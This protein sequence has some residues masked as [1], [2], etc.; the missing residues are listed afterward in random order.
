[1]TA[2]LQNRNPVG[3]EM[4]KARVSTNDGSE[5]DIGDILLVLFFFFLNVCVYGLNE[6]A[7]GVGNPPGA[8]VVGC[9]EVAS[10]G[11]G[12]ELRSSAQLLSHLSRLFVCF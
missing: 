3:L 8:G 2:G 5:R 11:A 10:V 12:I 6:W 7:K 4:T 1:M 9:W